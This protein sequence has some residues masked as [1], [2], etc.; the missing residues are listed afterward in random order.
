MKIANIMLGGG[1]G[2][3]EQAAVD[4]ARA[5]RNLGHDV[6]TIT[7]S[8][9]AIIPAL[10]AAQL[11]FLA[12][13]APQRW[14]L[15]ARLRIAR[16]MKGCD[17]AILHGN[18]AGEMVGAHPTRKNIAVAHSRFFTPLSHYHAVIA[19][20]AARAQEIQPQFRGPV[21]IIPNMIDLP[22]DAPR[23]PWRTPPIIGSMGRLSHE[24]GYDLLLDALAILR[25]KNIPFRAII[26]GD[27][28]EADA[29]KTQAQRLGIADAITW[30]GWVADK[31]AFFA[32]LDVYCMPSRTENFPITLLEAMAHG[33]PVLSTE[34]GGG[35]TEMLAGDGGILTP[36]TAE[37]V[38]AALAQAL[39]DPAEFAAMGTRARTKVAQHYA[40][41][42]VAKKLDDFLTALTKN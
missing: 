8:N 15:L 14:N 41:P 34:C 21:H 12:I 11:P 18:R 36:I 33:C 9:A 4:Y 19:L 32:S 3:V 1:R 16:A 27:G 39:V 20:S 35:P 42:V 24:K 37:G 17:I 2:G 13:R 30:A 10:N 22:P 23:A 40:T 25:S 29:L 38:A 7:R 26:G 6:L 28:K 5:L 31:A